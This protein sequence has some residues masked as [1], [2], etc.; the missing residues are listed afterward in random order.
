MMLRRF[1]GPSV[2][3][4]VFLA[5]GGRLDAAAGA[6]ETLLDAS[7]RGDFAAVTALLRPGVDV[8]AVQADGT[9]ALHW[10]AHHGNV[11]A[12]NR[13]IRAG[14]KV[15]AANRYGIT[16]IWLAARS[17][18][19]AVVEALLR[20]GADANSRRA[21]SGETVLMIAAQAGHAA[22]LQ[23]LIAHGADVNVK[24]KVRGQTELM[25]AAAEQHV[26][27]VR[28]LAEAGADL[29]ARSNGGMTPLM[30]AIRSGGIDVTRTML[31]AGA[32]LDARAPDGTTSLVLAMINA[33]W[34]LAKFLLD[35]GADPNGKDPHGAPLHVLAWMRR[36]EN[37]GLSAWLPRHDSGNISSI[38]LAEALIAKGAAVN[39]PQEFSG[40]PSHMALGLFAT[41][42]FKGA[43]P[44]W[45]ASKSC[46][47]EL[48]KFLVAHGADPSLATVEHV[49]P[50]QAAAGIGYTSGESPGTPEEALEAVKMLQALGNDVKTPTNFGTKGGG[51]MMGTKEGWDGS[52][53]LFG[54][55]IR[56][57]RQ[58]VEYLIAQGVPLAHRNKTGQTA[59]D[60][61][62]GSNL[63][64]TFH[65]Y[66]ELADV[67][68]KAM[69]A[70]GLPITESKT[71]EAR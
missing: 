8:N 13:M 57:G 60:L 10:A 54:A 36:A 33:H 59:L 26:A 65:V 14:A 44:F 45:I 20:A 41:L 5:G 48:M 67:I 66:P 24:E 12:V 18:H 38:Q 17:G 63:G 46:D 11:D 40:F 9:T 56:D 55:V 15:G 28:I 22:V 3:A 27:A 30:F 64:I 53:A 68:R 47:L 32:S 42:N 61:A 43:T 16:P 50:L 4:L 7:E 39:A 35:R 29:E 69:I 23:R 2:L 31:D 6:G 71:A 62:N 37:R 70:Q 1:I 52:T 25:W 21:D 51:G 49:T 34:E 19:A 58:L